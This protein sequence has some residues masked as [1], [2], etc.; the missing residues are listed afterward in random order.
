MNQITI[1]AAVLLVL[2][3]IFCQGSLLQEGLNTVKGLIGKN[4]GF[5][6]SVSSLCFL[7]CDGYFFVLCF[8]FVLFLFFLSFFNYLQ[9]FFPVLDALWKAKL[10]GEWLLWDQFPSC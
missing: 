2:G 8:G 1:L 9:K 3:L 4:V 7:L 6:Q 5:L 10:V